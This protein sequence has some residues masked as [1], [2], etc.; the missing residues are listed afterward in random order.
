MQTEYTLLQPAKTLAEAAATLVKRPLETQDQFDA[1]YSEKYGRA[2]GIDRFAHLR[3]EL[4][5]C[6]QGAPF[7]GFVMGHPG[8]GKSTEISRLLL[9]VEDKFRAIRL[10]VATEIYPGGFRLQ[11]LLWLMIVRMIEA[12]DSPTV[13]GFSGKLPSRLL[14]DVRAEMSQRWIETLGLRTGEL[15]GG[16][17]LPLIAKIRFNLKLQRTEKRQEFTLPELADLVILVNRVFEECNQ[18]LRQER[19]QEWILV[20]EDFEKHG[21][22]TD[23]LRRLFV[24]NSS[25]FERLTCHLLFVIPVGLAYS[26]DAERMPFG[27]ERQFVVPDIAVYRRNLEP[28]ESGIDAL[29]DVVYRRIDESLLDMRLAR[30]LAI[31]SGGNIRDLFDL[32]HRASLAAEVRGAIQ[33]ERDDSLEAVRNLRG[34]YKQQLGE[35]FFDAQNKITIK[36]KLAKLTA[37]YR[38]EPTAQIADRVLYLLLRHR[39]VLQFNG[40]GWYGVHPLVVD[41]LKEQGDPY[42][43]PGEPGGSD[44]GG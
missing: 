36:D 43:R 26:E 35:T 34:I 2:R 28:D 19:K 29:F 39:M 16:L 1:F 8:V 27:R 15:D 3:I 30:S 38:G 14:E 18:V 21:I 33:I 31:A 12:T 40:E 23:S 32:L 10:S 42:V 22:A 41:I 13:I 11:D 37:L 44:L 20:V 5:R 9:R 24:D 25:L 4:T 6:F 17:G 7:H